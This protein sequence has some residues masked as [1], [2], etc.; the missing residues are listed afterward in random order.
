MTT[1]LEPI[2]N[3]D[4]VRRLLAERN[5]HHVKVGVVD[6][7]GILRGKYMARDKFASSLDGGF[8]F[9]DVVLGWDS[10]DQLYDGVQLTGWHTGYP[11]ASARIVPETARELP[12]EDGVLFFLAEFTGA[13]AAI[14]PRNVLRRILVRAEAAGYRAKVGSEFEFFV[15]D[16]T[17]QSVR[18][19]GFRGLRPFTPGNFGYSTLRSSVHASLYRTLLDS[20]EAMNVPIEALHTETGPGVLEAALRVDDALE[21]ADKAVLFKTFTK[22]LA[23]RAGLMATFMA[24]WSPDVPGQSG[25]LHVSL[26]DRDGTP[27]FHDPSA[28]HAMSETMR[29]FVG[30]QQRLMPELLSM[31]AGTVNSYTRLI[32]GYWAPTSAS[33]GVDNRTCALRV[34]PGSAKSQR[35]EYRVAAADINPYLAIA[36]AIASGLWGIENRIEPTAPVTGSAYHQPADAALDLPRTLT[37]AAERLAESAAARDLFGA[38]FVT[39][40]AET[41]RWEERAHRRAIT[42][43]QLARYFEII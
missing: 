25:H 42:D 26:T 36:V 28:P 35:V 32:P 38:E 2:R 20:F 22:V 19:K 37:D 15:F 16:E 29:W 9:C 14:C 34:I 5:P 12:F 6:I 40:Y 13:A 10:N 1:P 39:H 23:Q 17:P 24:K 4:D 27:L 43:W 31:V 33:W 30:G 41:R 18:D 21:A 3:E 11:D 8:G 7:D